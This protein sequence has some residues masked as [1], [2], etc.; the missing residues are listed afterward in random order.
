[1]QVGVENGTVPYYSV[2]PEF[3]PFIQTMPPGGYPPPPPQGYNPI[4]FPNFL[5]CL[6]GESTSAVGD[7][8]SED[9]ISY[10][11]GVSF[12]GSG[13][14]QTNAYPSGDS[15]IVYVKCPS[16]SAQEDYTLV[17]S[18][19]AGVEYSQTVRLIVGAPS[20]NMNTVSFPTSVNCNVGNFTSVNGSFNTTNGAV[21][22]TGSFSGANQ[23]S[24]GLTITSGTTFTVEVICAMVV[25]S[26]TV[27][28]DVTD[29]F[30]DTYS[31]SVTFNA[32]P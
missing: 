24:L 5:E 14:F 32:V 10:L 3:A 8:V 13:S 27:A 16:S 7:Y 22:S 25:T 6:P 26:E 20:S 12:S 28:L 29:S 18:D 23:F 30:G 19:S 31:Q 11:S 21:L 9:G 15:F 4:Q 17:V 1:M 2:P